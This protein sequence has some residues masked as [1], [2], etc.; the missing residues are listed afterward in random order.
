MRNKVL[1][2]VLLLLCFSLCGCVGDADLQEKYDLGYEDGY[3]IGYEEGYEQGK[4][5]GRAEAWDEFVAALDNEP[6]DDVA[7]DERGIEGEPYYVNTKE[8]PLNIR[9]MP[10]QDTDIVGS[11]PKGADIEIY[12]TENGFGYTTYAGAEGWVN[13]DYCKEGKNP[14]PPAEYSA[15]TVYITNTGEKYHKD[16]CQH[17]HSSKIPVTLDE[18]LSRGLDPCKD[19]H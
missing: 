4:I 18:A 11:I 9:V 8:T 3:N 1:F 15:D 5:D 13:L 14:N 19:C 12:Y 6:M 16:G 7:I 10:Q 2:A 17:L